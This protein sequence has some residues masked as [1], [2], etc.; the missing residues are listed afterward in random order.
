MNMTIYLN[1]G[2][3]FNAVI[4]NFNAAEF[5]QT[6]NNPQ[7]AFVSIGNIVLSKH[8]VM[9]ILPTDLLGEQA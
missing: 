1:N 7:I 9:M 4:E 8:A 3:Q 2:L 6:Q 5:A